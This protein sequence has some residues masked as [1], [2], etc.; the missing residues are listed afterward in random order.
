MILILITFTRLAEYIS[1]LIHPLSA[2]R[3]GNCPVNGSDRNEIYIHTY[4]YILNIRTTLHF[5]IQC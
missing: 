1:N 4:I 3:T 2:V 5:K